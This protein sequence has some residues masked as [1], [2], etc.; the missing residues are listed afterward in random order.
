MIC[1]LC[2]QDKE[3][4]RSHLVPEFLYRPLYDYP[5]EGP[6]KR[7]YR[8]G[9]GIAVKRSFEQKG[10]REKLLCRECEKHINKQ[11]ENYVAGIWPGIW[12]R[13][14]AQ[15]ENSP[16][17]IEFNVDYK[18]FK[19]FQL[20]LLWRTSISSLPDFADIKIGKPE[21]DHGDFTYTRHEERIRKMLLNGNPGEEYDYGCIILYSPKLTKNIQDALGFCDNK[22]IDNYRRYS[23]FIH[24]TSWNYIVSSH[25][26]RFIY[27]DKFLQKDRT[28]PV[29]FDFGIIKKNLLK[30]RNLPH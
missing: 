29:F 4:Q 26:E 24:G 20:S 28:L 7:F 12:T 25:M 23:I 21:I 16:Q 27:K 22:R 8:T 6:K 11:C 30:L 10:L 9:F 2:L 13:L 14:A 5:D 18:K 3:L 19:L 17:Q 1:R 15:S